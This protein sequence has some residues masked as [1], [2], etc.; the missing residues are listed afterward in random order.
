MG[1]FV[2]PFSTDH[3]SV[4]GSLFGREA[5]RIWRAILQ[6]GIAAKDGALE[7][8]QGAENCGEPWP[9]PGS[10]LMSKRGQP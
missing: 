2:L 9:S 4:S 10:I 1:S 3:L 8:G 6:K 7:L 5:T